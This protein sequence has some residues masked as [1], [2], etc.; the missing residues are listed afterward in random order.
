MLSK[1]SCSCNLAARNSFWM[2]LISVWWSRLFDT[3]PC[4]VAMVCFIFSKTCSVSTFSFF[5]SSSMTSFAFNAFASS[6]TR[7]PI[8]FCSRF[9][10]R[11]SLHGFCR[12]DRLS[13]APPP[14]PRPMAAIPASAPAPWCI[15]AEKNHTVP[16]R[17]HPLSN[18]LLQT[19]MCSTR[20][21]GSLDFNHSFTSV[22][23]AMT[24]VRDFN[25]Y[26]L[27]YFHYHAT[28]NN[29]LEMIGEG[30]YQHTWTVFSAQI[31]P[32]LEHVTWDVEIRIIYIY[33]YI[34]I[35]INGYS[36]ILWT[37]YNHRAPFDLIGFTKHG[38]QG[39]DNDAN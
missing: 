10:R 35:Y 9:S 17:P 3:V 13:P 39:L 34:Y 18:R 32:V 4:M 12:F 1:P 27:F 19:S 26:Q 22:P 6:S 14:E 38:P 2:R 16:S 37:Q 31:R 25:T 5:M 30:F 15:R 36:P 8:R 7:S 21:A 11:R 28:Y 24:C 29:A 20:A 23:Q 33:I